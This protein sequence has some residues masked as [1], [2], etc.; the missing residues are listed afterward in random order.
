MFV[1]ITGLPVEQ[2]YSPEQHQRTPQPGGRPSQQ[3]QIKG[4]G[5]VYPIILQAWDGN[6]GYPTFH[7]SHTLIIFW[8]GREP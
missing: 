1:Q 5:V 4:S 3:N 2:P 8:M 6:T 7:L